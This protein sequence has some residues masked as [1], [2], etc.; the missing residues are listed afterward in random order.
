MTR[1][2][3][4]AAGAAGGLAL[5]LPGE[6]WWGLGSASSLAAG[7][8]MRFAAR[9]PVPDVISA[10][11]ITLTARESEVQVLPG[12]KTRMWT[13]GGSFPGPTIRRP[14]GE[15]TS[16]T[17]R[18][19]LPRAG[20]LTL[21]LHG[22][23]NTEA[24]DGQPGGPTKSDRNALY[25]KLTRGST[26]A[27]NRF[28]IAPG[29]QRRY[30]FA[31]REDGAD[32][33][34]AFQWYHDHRCGKTAE[35]IWRG[36]AGMWI[37][38]DDHDRSLPLPEGR[39][40]LALMVSDRSF[41]RDN[42]LTDAYERSGEPPFDGT[43]GSRVLVNGKWLPYHPVEPVRH[44]VRVLNASLFRSY[45]LAL[46]DNA[47]FT[48]I[49]TDSGLLPAPMDLTRMLIGPGERVELI[50]DFAQF[51]GTNVTNV[52]L[53][54]RPRSPAPSP[55]GFGAQSYDGPLMQFR[56]SSTSVTDNSEVPS[57][58]RPLPTWTEQVDS[59]DE[60][61]FTWELGVAGTFGPRTWTINGKGFDPSRVDRRVKLGSIP[62]WR[63]ANPT[64]TAHLMHLHHTDWYV[65]RRERILDG[66]GFETVPTKPGDELKDTFFLDPKESIVV[67]GKISDYLGKFIVHCHMLDHEDHGLMSQFEVVP[68]S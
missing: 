27:A 54:S 52:V 28:L 41:D 34:A 53:S 1:R 19:R 10:A 59:N 13:Y 47:E 50:V 63:L 48:L 60:P 20:R 67:A 38:D 56:V 45:N 68:A 11:D 15:T 66:G 21:H 57:S 65:L 46:P 49:G 37:L 51:R 12:R 5:A 43:K 32:E 29:K 6:R 61:G 14:S 26:A 3:V 24:D 8:P 33:R 58:L 16:L 55:S 17:L 64:P 35:N 9:L 40:D 25:C 39:R 30:R 44:R 7:Q 42:Q 18:H 22:G 2:A 62:V 23:H 31:A 4:V 36:L